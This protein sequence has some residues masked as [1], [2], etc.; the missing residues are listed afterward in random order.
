MFMTHTRGLIKCQHREKRFKHTLAFSV[1]YPLCFWPVFSISLAH[2]WCLSVRIYIRS[3][4]GLLV[5]F[6]MLGWEG[7]RRKASWA[8]MTDSLCLLRLVRSVDRVGRVIKSRS[9]PFLSSQEWAIRFFFSREIR[10]G[11]VAPRR[12]AECP[13]ARRAAEQNEALPVCQFDCSSRF[14]LSFTERVAFSFY[15]PD[16]IKFWND[17]A[18][19]AGCRLNALFVALFTLQ[20]HVCTLAPH[21]NDPSVEDVTH[22]TASTA[23]WFLQAEPRGSWDMKMLWIYLL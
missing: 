2:R 11:T 10:L 8:Y 15:F 22:G 12:D 6:L 17:S 13:G 5:W 9:D 19:T 18:C 20:T 7:A 14:W 21:R 23:C 16:L 4:G 3:G 1:F